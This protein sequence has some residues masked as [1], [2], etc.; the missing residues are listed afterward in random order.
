MSV[1]FNT[2]SKRGELFQWLRGT[3]ELLVLPYITVSQRAALQHHVD[4]MAAVSAFDVK[5]EI[6][7]D[8]KGES[9]KIVIYIQPTR[10]T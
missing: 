5:C 1:L 2:L 6:A 9:M 3:A 4:K 7:Q 8:A 10:A